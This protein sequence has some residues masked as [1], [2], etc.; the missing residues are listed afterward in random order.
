MKSRT[1]HLLTLAGVVGT[2]TLLAV[3]QQPGRV[4]PGK[5]QESARRP[6]S[7]RL[8]TGPADTMRSAVAGGPTVRVYF[9]PAPE[10]GT[11][12]NYP[13]G[14]TIVGQDMNA[15]PGSS[16]TALFNVQI[17]DWDLDGNGIPLLHLYQVRISP[18]DFLGANA[19]P[20]EPGC[21]LTYPF[22]T[23]AC[24]IGAAGN[25]FCGA[26]WEQGS[27]CIGSFCERGF[28]NRT[29]LDWIFR[30]AEPNVVG[31]VD[32]ASPDAIRFGMVVTSPG[33]DAADGHSLYYA[34]TLAL[35][36]PACASS[37][38][39]INIDPAQTFLQDELNQDIP[40]VALISGR[41]TF[42]ATGSCC[43]GIG[44]PAAGCTNGL[45]EP[46][47]GDNEPAPF[48]WNP[49]G[50]CASSCVLGS[51]CF[52][53]GSPAANCTDGL[54]QAQCGDNEP[55]PFVWTQGGA[56]SSACVLGS[57]CFGIGSPG[58]GCTDDLIA[59]TCGD[60]EPA[61]FVF[62][63]GGLCSAGCG[64]GGNSAYTF[65]YQ[66]S[67][68]KDGA[69]VNGTADLV[70]SLWS[71]DIGG[72][73]V[74]TDFEVA[75]IP[76]SDGTFSAELDF[77]PSAPFDGSPRWLEVA[78]RSP[79][80]SGIY[81]TLLPRVRMWP[82]PQA[83]HALRATA[84]LALDA[85]DGSPID[86]VYVDNEGRVGIGTT[87]PVNPLQMASG[88]HCTVGG[89]W[90][91]ASGRELKENFAEVNPRQVLDRVIELPVRAWNYKNE[92]SLVRH[93]GPMA[94]EFHQSF[95]LGGDDRSIGTIDAD[96]VALAA[97]QGLHQIVQEKDC[98]M[99]GLGSEISNLKSQISDLKAMIE[100]LTTKQNGGE[101]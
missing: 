36:V 58:A 54:P 70:A 60:N 26:S 18:S 21:D 42:P 97:I 39:T 43:F 38:Y 2:A 55:G 56:C 89:V 29:R 17:E 80:G 34:G 69:A 11:A 63:P 6:A 73:Q 79:S 95:A 15:V 100:A 7:A 66:G 4:E 72:P 71:D 8:V 99:E 67:L 28:F 92:S 41:L 62:T 48:V 33:F 84:A 49:G 57:C 5:T 32:L 83:Q 75:A 65:V 9:T 14:T 23:L 10:G 61:P 3:A 93:M 12:S 76:V 90:T 45:T 98:Q 52:G 25:A 88:A 53:L 47:C 40:Y 30:T 50:N 68:E 82:A 96:G 24:T 16:F 20:S 78:V 59:S 27:Q 46:Q 44:T 13:P 22:Q 37:T 74:G 1:I 77:G 85:P 86:A 31:G 19:V 101:K 81:T 91:N 51:C 35:S 94:E 87:A 64:S